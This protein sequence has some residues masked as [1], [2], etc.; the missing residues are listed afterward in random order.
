MYIQDLIQAN[1]VQ[2]RYSATCLQRT[3]NYVS[4]WE[5]FINLTCISRTPV[6]TG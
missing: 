3:L 4:L 1:E 2:N 6:Y 5:I